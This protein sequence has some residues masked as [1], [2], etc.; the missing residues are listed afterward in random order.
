[1]LAEGRFFGL[2]RSC[3]S[4]LLLL[5]F[6]GAKRTATKVVARWRLEL[7]SCWL[8]EVMWAGRNALPILVLSTEF[9]GFHSQ[10]AEVCS[11]RMVSA[12]TSETSI[13][14][15]MML[16]TVSAGV[17]YGPGISS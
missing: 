6:S 2:F 15:G 8:L 16:K 13:L 17:G 9:G 7:G 4:W 10:V 14:V 5:M 11:I 1:M 3:N 12:L